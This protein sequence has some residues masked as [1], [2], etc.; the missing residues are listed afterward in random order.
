VSS[1]TEPGAATP[2]GNVFM[3]IDGVVD[4]MKGAN[5]LL[6]AESLGGIR[7][8]LAPTLRSSMIPVRA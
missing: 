1:G 6:L 7:R 5:A 3:A 4:G 8:G 2:P